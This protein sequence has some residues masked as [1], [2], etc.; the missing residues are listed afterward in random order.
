MTRTCFNCACLCE[1]YWGHTCELDGEKIP[2][3]KTCDVWYPNYEEEVKLLREEN[4]QL[5]ERIH[6]MQWIP[7][8]ERLPDEYQDV[9]IWLCDGDAEYNVTFD[10]EIF[11][12][13]GGEG[14][15]IG[16]VSHWM[17][18]PEP[19]QKAKDGDNNG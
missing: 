10:G 4:K 18:L 7:V 5:K 13:W 1:G 2:E 8:S 17:P 19:P 9:H 16:E 3:S 6:K 12:R 14:Y 11:D 15:K